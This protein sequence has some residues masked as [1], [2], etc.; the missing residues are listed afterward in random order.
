MAGDWRRKRLWVDN[1]EPAHPSWE[2][3]GGLCASTSSASPVPKHRA[4]AGAELCVRP[5]L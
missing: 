3:K 4:A 1:E 2:G 5:Q